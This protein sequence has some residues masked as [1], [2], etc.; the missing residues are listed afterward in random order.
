MTKTNIW[1]IYSKMDPKYQDKLDKNLVVYDSLYIWI[2]NM[3]KFHN[4]NIEL[5]GK[6]DFLKNLRWDEGIAPA[7]YFKLGKY[8]SKDGR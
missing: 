3:R 8:I 1:E 4:H 5:K 7:K 2:T 6:L